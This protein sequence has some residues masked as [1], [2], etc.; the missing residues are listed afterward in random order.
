M[1]WTELLMW[2]LNNNIKPMVSCRQNSNVYYV[3][4]MCLGLSTMR[5][6]DQ[7]PFDGQVDYDYIMWIDSDQVFNPQQFERVLSHDKDIMCGL[8][9]MQNGRQFTAVE[10]WDDDY[11]RKN[12]TFQFMQPEDI[13]DKK[14]ILE[15]EYSGM[16]FM[17]V[18]K[19]VYEKL[20]YP[21]F[22][23]ITYDFGNDVKEFMSEDVSFCRRAKK[24]GF[25][26]YV[27]PQ[28]V[29]GHEKKVVL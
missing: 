17:L 27:D 19:G 14:E 18:K 10:K 12:G 26:I 23:P 13:K 4:S 2:C 3:R 9:L 25:K 7:K 1:S 5:G 24:A 6:P 8:Y 29:V 28:V 11:Y 20:A 16:G 22:S 15:V 21:Y